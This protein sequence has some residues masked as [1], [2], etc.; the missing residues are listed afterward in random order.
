MCQAPAD[1]LASSTGGMA[2]RNSTRRSASGTASWHL[3]PP[4]TTPGWTRTS[5][6]GIRNLRRD[7]FACPEETT[8]CDVSRCRSTTSESMSGFASTASFTAQRAEKAA[9]L[10]IPQI[11]IGLRKSIRPDLIR[12][13]GSPP[14]GEPLPER[15]S[16]QERSLMTPTPRRFSEPD[17]AHRFLLRRTA[18][19]AGQVAVVAPSK[20]CLC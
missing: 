2:N 10:R 4:T 11:E 16:P 7:D 12:G 17:R 15:E 8:K 9:D 20:C 13:R 14:D 5:D 18:P 1:E 3:S 19:S 6:P